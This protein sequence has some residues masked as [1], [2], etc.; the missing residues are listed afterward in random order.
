MK[1][2]INITLSFIFIIIS[3]S[4]ALAYEHS[5]R[6]N[7]I[8]FPEIKFTKQNNIFSLFNQYS[9]NKLSANDFVI[10]A[11]KIINSI[12]E[13]INIDISSSTN[14]NM[15]IYF[16][17][18]TYANYNYLSENAIEEFRKTP[19][20]FDKYINK[21]FSSEE[22]NIL[23]SHG[24]KYLSG[25]G[26]FYY[27]LIDSFQKLAETNYISYSEAALYM[28]LIGYIDYGLELNYNIDVKEFRCPPNYILDWIS[29][30]YSKLT[31]KKIMPLLQLL[32]NL[33]FT[34]KLKS[35]NKNKKSKY[36]IK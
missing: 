1:K 19:Y 17:A 23:H 34:I 3:S 5:G 35:L 11:S 28:L 7:Y 21:E 2:I 25:N 30:N 13:N 27:N 12:D 9:I 10:K 29:T 20:C 15:I 31:D 24:K 18:F 14:E 32:D 6:I 26:N 16:V 4:L 36:L 22:I 33:N 8:S